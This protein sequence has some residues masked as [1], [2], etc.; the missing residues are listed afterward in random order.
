MTDDGIH[1]NEM[2]EE[3]VA[4]DAPASFIV[5]SKEGNDEFGNGSFES[6]LL[7]IAAAIALWSTARNTI[8]VAPGEYDEEALVWPNINNLTLAALVPGTVVITNN[9]SAAQV[10]AI[11][12]T[13]TAS[14]FGATIKGIALS[15]V[16]Q[17]GLKVANAAMTKKLNV[18]L[19]GLTCEADSTGNSITVAGTVSGQAIRVYAKDL[20]CENLVSFAANDAGSRLRIRNGDLTGGLTTTGAVAAE[21]TIRNV[22]VLTS[23]L[24]V[25]AE[26]TLCNIG[27]VYA[28]DADP[29]VH[30]QFAD[31]YAG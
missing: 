27:C 22:Q 15:T 8:L 20:D 6:P 17:I 18:Y 10:L 11:A 4:F 16:A 25:A 28:T 30:S 12:P 5:V 9:D 1:R 24:S 31:A 7:T 19:E 21:C 23:G 2:A 29:T 14:T 26:W 3:A 13:W